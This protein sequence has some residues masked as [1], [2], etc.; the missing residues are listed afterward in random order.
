MP[1]N[2]R[3]DYG[4]KTYRDAKPGDSETI[5]PKRRNK[6]YAIYEKNE[7]VV[8]DHVMKPGPVL[9][10]AMTGKFRKGKKPKDVPSAS[11][12]GDA[13]AAHFGKKKKAAVGGRRESFDGVRWGRGR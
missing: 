3:Y 7:T 6:D 11:A 4:D 2:S 8:E 13:L 5:P 12:V 9:S 1:H 10:K